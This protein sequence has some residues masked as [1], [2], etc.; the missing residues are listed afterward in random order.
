MRILIATVTAG[1]GHVQAAAALEEAWRALRPRD[2]LQRLDVLSFTPR[3]YRKVY[4]DGYVKIVEH[5]P[6]LYAHVFKKT[7]NPAL[8]K[9]LTRFRRTLAH[10]TTNKFVTQL[11]KFK[12]DA[13]LCTH[14]LP[15]EILAHLRA[16]KSKAL[17]PM[18]V[19]IITDF[20]AHALWMEAGVDLYCVAAE[21]TKARLVARGAP[22]ESVAVT[23]IPISAKFSADVDVPES[24]KRMGLRDDLP[25]LLV[26][27]GGFGLGPVAEILA[28][29]DKLPMTVQVLVVCGRNQELRAKLAL[30]ERRQPTRIL[31]FVSNMHELMAI[32]EIVISKPGGLTTS[33]ALAV[34]KPLFV[35]NPIPGQEAANSDFLLEHG[36]AAK[37]NRVE[38]LPY[39]LEKLLGSSKLSEMAA[40]ARSLAR[41][42]AAVEICRAVIH[43]LD[44]SPRLAEAL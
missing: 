7:D 40:A 4:V 25:I 27:S 9:K 29:V 30:Q 43:R 38:D 10:L 22:E 2:A 6:E 32:A 41:P 8:V 16:R 19:S 15:L 17:A 18:T 5:A 23:G 3:L 13:V 20:E 44:K 33:E 12:P 37:A 21:E 34:G 11:R 24:R 35:L 28:E 36:A 14:Y 26:L 1:A 31:G 39:R 42:D